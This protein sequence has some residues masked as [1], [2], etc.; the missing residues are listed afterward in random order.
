M[1]VHTFGLHLLA[2]TALWCTITGVAWAVLVLPKWLD[3]HAHIHADTVNA[4]SQ[5]LQ[6]MVVAI[7]G[8]AQ[9]VL[10]SPKMLDLQAVVK[11]ANAVHIRV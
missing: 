2:C 5:Q 8:A 10:M 7:T 9:A 4:E 1:G 11:H 3:L 6:H